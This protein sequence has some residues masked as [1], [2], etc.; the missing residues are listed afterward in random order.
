MNRE[1]YTR[2]DI[3]DI[4]DWYSS[5]VDTVLSDRV[6]GSPATT[7]YPNLTAELYAPGFYGVSSIAEAARVRPKTIVSAIERGTSLYPYQLERLAAALHV[8]V[9][10]LS[11]PCMAF[12]NPL[13]DSGAAQTAQLGALLEDTKGLV[14]PYIGRIRSG[15]DKL[16]AERPILYA[17]YKADIRILLSAKRH[18]RLSRL[19]GEGRVLYVDYEPIGEAVQARAKQNAAPPGLERR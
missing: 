16:C 14:V 18:P 3:A 13:T 4:Q 12:V 10:Y 1:K 2:F 8:S 19:R 6:A 11:A 5:I 17:S 7:R 15:Y 9:E